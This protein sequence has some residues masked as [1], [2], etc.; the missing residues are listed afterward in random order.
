M[1]PFYA[2]QRMRPKSRDDE[3]FRCDVTG[4]NVSLPINQ[5]GDTKVENYLDNVE[6]EG[7]RC[8][9]RVREPIRQ[10]R[11]ILSL[12]KIQVLVDRA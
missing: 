10:N 4:A 12:T 7:V 8:L 2:M 5:L 9:G 6:T 11:K 1:P 3:K